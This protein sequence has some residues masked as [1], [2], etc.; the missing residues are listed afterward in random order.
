MSNFKNTYLST[1]LASALL[2]TSNQCLATLIVTTGGQYATDG[3]GLTSA[4][5]NANNKLDPSDGYL[6]ETFDANTKMI[7]FELL[8][9]D[10]SFNWGGLNLNN[11]TSAGC[12]INS[13]ALISVTGNI[14][15]KGDGSDK[16]H[17]IGA[18]PGGSNPLIGD[19]T[20]FGF[21]PGLGQGDTVTVD[22]SNFLSNG[23][24]IDYFGFYWG[25]VDSYNDFTFTDT[26]TNTSETLFGADLLALSGGVPGSRTSPNS[27]LYVNI[28][29]EN[30]AFNKF[31]VR[32][33]GVAGEFDNIVV[34][35]QSRKISEPAS[36]FMF[37]FALIALSWVRS[38]SES[39]TR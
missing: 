16:A 10:K 1:L 25:S 28:N 4:F 39:S 18:P 17:G 11:S 2:F 30:F 32:S 21:T 23:D 15:V 9:Q 12:G 19:K 36:I 8:P 27:N 7:G 37:S 14:G 24:K 3:S 6:I 22:Y 33:T 26:N 38:K 34:G 29:F 5:I 20:C 35:L 13:T 31:T